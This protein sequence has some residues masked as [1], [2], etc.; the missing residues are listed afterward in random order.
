MDLTNQRRSDNVIYDCLGIRT[1]V[2]ADH[3]QVRLAM[4]CHDLLRESAQRNPKEAAIN[5]GRW[6]AENRSL[7]HRWNEM[8]RDLSTGAHQL[9]SG[10][11]D[12]I[13]FDDIFESI[14]SVFSPRSLEQQ[15]DE[16]RESMPDPVIKSDVPPGTGTATTSTD[17]ATIDCKTDGANDRRTKNST[18]AG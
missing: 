7:E 5:S 14:G 18:I 10:E 1:P 12:Q 15:V 4:T 11:L 9:F 13:R 16:I 8:T 6:S 17:A 2:T 3:D